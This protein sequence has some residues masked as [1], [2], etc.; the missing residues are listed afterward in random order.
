MLSFTLISF[1]VIEY[2]LNL[3]KLQNVI[4]IAST[5]SYMVG[6]IL[7]YFA[8]HL[9][10]FNTKIRSNK[11]LF[12]VIYSFFISFIV[13]NLTLIIINFSDDI[14]LQ[15]LSFPIALFVLSFPTFFV[16]KYFIFKK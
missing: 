9:F 10:V 3:Y 12:F 15:K 4:Y 7:N 16:N 8:Q 1:S 14:L 11:F 5:T 6:V 2:L 13:G